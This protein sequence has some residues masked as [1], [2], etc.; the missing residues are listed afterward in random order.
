MKLIWKLCLDIRVYLKRFQNFDVGVTE[1]NLIKEKELEEN[2]EKIE[3]IIRFNGYYDLF[4]IKKWIKPILNNFQIKDE[5]TFTKTTDFVVVKPIFLNKT[6]ETLETMREDITKLSWV[7]TTNYN[8]KIKG[9]LSS[10]I[11][12]HGN[13]DQTIFRS[14]MNGGNRDMKGKDAN[15]HNIRRELFLKGEYINLYDEFDLWKYHDQGFTGKGVKVAIFDSGISSESIKHLN[16]VTKIDFTND[17]EN[18]DMTSHGT[19]IA[20]VI[21]SRHSKCPGIAPDAELYIFKVF[22]KDHNSYTEWFLNAFNFALD[23]GIDI[24][25]LSNGSSDFKDSP[26]I[27][28]INEV[29]EKG[30]TVV[31]SIGN[32][33]PDQGTLNNPADMVNVIGVGSLNYNKDNLASFSSRGITT[34]NLLKEFGNFKP[35]IITLG[36]KVGG[37]DLSGICTINSGTSISSGIVSGS[38]ALILSSMKNK[39]NPASIK[40]AIL[41]SSNRL[42]LIP[43]SDQGNG[44]FNIDDTISKL[45]A[46]E[47][48]DPYIHPSKLDFTS[49]EYLPFSLVSFYSTMMPIALN[50]TVINPKNPKFEIIDIKGETSDILIKECIKIDYEYSSQ[51][52]SY[53]YQIRMRLSII[54]NNQWKIASVENGRIDTYIKFKDSNLTSKYSI[55]LKLVPTPERKNRVLIDSFHNLKFPENGYIQ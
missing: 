47:L 13:Y 5:H 6:E 28:K 31:S 33:G 41:Q 24:I 44:I 1:D 32:D 43:I 19:F 12:L 36:E 35:D 49:S 16:I 23:K 9:N 37:L 39:P 53:Y 14:G 42:P 26:F 29:V 52:A 21:G 46:K 25:N 15:S 2:R 34:W 8:K 30:I 54:I 45:N 22:N 3:L 55:V 40:S 18:N 11:N 38:I 50:F 10:L 48:L 51:S 7:K 27:D 20:S 4:E 17:S